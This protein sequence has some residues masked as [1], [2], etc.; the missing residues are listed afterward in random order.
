M[1]TTSF[2]TTLAAC[3]AALMLPSFVFADDAEDRL[4]RLDNDGNGRVSRAEF[5]AKGERIFAKI[6]KDQNGKL[7]LSEL[8]AWNEK[9]E[10]K[11]DDKRPRSGWGRYERD[12]DNELS[13]AERLKKLDTNGDDAVSLK[14]FVEARKDKFKMLDKDDDGS[15]KESELD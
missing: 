9:R 1:K 11:E 3:C 10:D 8:R 4:D 2:S 7:T 15:L 14:E 12:E 5:V 13:P 6:D